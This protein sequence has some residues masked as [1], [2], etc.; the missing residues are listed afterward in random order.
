MYNTKETRDKLPISVKRF[1]A[2]RKKIERNHLSLHKRYGIDKEGN[3]PTIVVLQGMP[4]VS[5]NI[6]FKMKDESAESYMEVENRI[7]QCLQLVNQI[8]D[9]KEKPLDK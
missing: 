9:L 7:K 1:N 3:Y 4:G 6:I 5:I 8:A 2:L